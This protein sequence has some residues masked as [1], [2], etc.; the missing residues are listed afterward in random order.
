MQQPSP[1]TTSDS[2][3]VVAT[4]RPPGSSSLGET[5][6]IRKGSESYRPPH[7]ASGSA[8]LHRVPTSPPGEPGVSFARDVLIDLPRSSTQGEQYMTTRWLK[9]TVMI[10]CLA[11]GSIP[12]AASAQ[13]SGS[14]ST[15]SGASSQSSTSKM[16]DKSKTDSSSLGAGG[17]G[18]TGT[19]SST[20]PS[21]TGGSGDQSATG[22]A[23]G[24]SNLPPN[25]PDAPPSASGT[26]SSTDTVS[27]PAKPPN[28]PKSS[29]R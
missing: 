4:R 12:L 15:G 28:K 6:E 1:S 5:K 9:R 19:G 11:T 17:S 21:G 23:S 14:T 25:S 8:V 13:T 18:T 2:T 26:G 3:S 20:T 7:R 29:G 27:P 16:D 10:G 22:S 24:R